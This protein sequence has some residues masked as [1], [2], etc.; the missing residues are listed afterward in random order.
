MNITKEGLLNEFERQNK[1]RFR[2]ESDDEL[3]R[4][5]REVEAIIGRD[6]GAAEEREGEQYELE[7]GKAEVTRVG[8][9]VGGREEG[10]S[11]RNKR[12]RR[13]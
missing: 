6:Y 1:I 7:K 3:E 13:R 12:A 10:S 9:E 4:Y 5:C 2:Q 11:R 8:S